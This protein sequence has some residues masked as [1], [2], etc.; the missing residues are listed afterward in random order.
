MTDEEATAAFNAARIRAREHVRTVHGDGK[1]VR[2][3]MRGE[4]KA[5]EPETGKLTEYQR[6]YVDGFDAPAN[7]KARDK[8]AVIPEGELRDAIADATHNAETDGALDH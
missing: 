3:A 2:A 4:I 6:G 1:R 5:A 8:G 7:T